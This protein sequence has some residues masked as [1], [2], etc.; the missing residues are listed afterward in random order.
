MSAAGLLLALLAAGPG[1]A[2]EAGAP[3]RGLPAL[4]AADPTAGPAGADPAGPRSVAVLVLS[5]EA[6]SYGSGEVFAAARAAIETHTTLRVAPAERVA[7]AASTET[8]VACAGDASCFALAVDRLGADVDLLVTVATDR[9]GPSTVLGLRL[10]DVR[11]AVSGQGGAELAA[12]GDALPEGAS[13]LRAMGDY[14]GRLF[15]PRLWGE[16]ARLRVDTDRPGAT[17]TVGARTCTA[18]C[19]F[20]RLAP[21]PVQLVV[22]KDG[23]EPFQAELHLERGAERAVYAELTAA[24]SDGLLASPWLWVAV[25]VAAVGLGTAGY[26]ALRPEGAPDRAC[27]AATVELCR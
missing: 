19:S 21:G 3:L 7:A 24:S 23:F 8:S 25:G 15:P 11:R 14:L 13:L 1:S 4:A 6:A 9:I 20:D 16:V 26:F 10:I 18:P 12:L 22:T 5:G 17:A 27:I 2:P